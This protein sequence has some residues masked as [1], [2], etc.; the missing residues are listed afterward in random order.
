M[1]TFTISLPEEPGRLAVTRKRV[2]DVDFY[3]SAL[4][5]K[6]RAGVVLIQEEDTAPVRYEEWRATRSEPLLEG[7]CPLSMI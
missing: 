3:V 5:A 6:G 4:R 7:G 2:V 1:E